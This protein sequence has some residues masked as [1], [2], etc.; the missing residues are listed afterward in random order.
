VFLGKK[1]SL[2]AEYGKVKIPLKMFNNP[3]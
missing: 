1:I 3:L 2:I